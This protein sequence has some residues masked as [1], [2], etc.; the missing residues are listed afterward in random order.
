MSV[1]RVKKEALITQTIFFKAESENEFESISPSFGYNLIDIIA[2][3]IAGDPVTPTS[4]S[5]DI[6]VRTDIDGGFKRI[7]ERSNYPVSL[8]G[9]SGLADGVALEAKFVG[10]P[11]EFK[12]VP[13][14]VDVAVSYRVNIK[15]SSVQLGLATPVETS[16]RGTLGV[17]V[18]IQD[19]TTQSLD[20]LFS[21]DLDT[22][23]LDGATTVSS[24]F[25]DVAAGD[26][27]KFAVGNLI[28]IARNSTFMQAHVLG[29][30]SD[31]IEIESPINSV[32][33]DGNTVFIK[34]DN[35]KVDGSVTPQVF[36]ISPEP[37][38]VGDI[39]RI[40]I[41]LEGTLAMDSGTF[42]PLVAL[43]NG[44]VLRI[45]KADGDFIN[46][47]NFKTN[48]DIVS[49]SFAH[50]FLPNNG[51]NVRLFVAQLTW[52]G[53]QNHGVTQRL[54]GNFFEELQ[55]VIQ[56][57]LTNAAFVTFVLTAQGHETQN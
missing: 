50:S 49:K 42:G 55:I 21:Q 10:F 4:G 45:K 17:P 7:T 34:D 36:S 35:L 57:D 11:L 19:Q 56:D 43:T 41:S 14:N 33:P 8:T 20:L 46:L 52:A 51:Q 39:N 44:V 24:R 22:A 26:G 53:S 47:V 27:T 13:N 32:Y 29:I 48:G 1:K 40:I 6:F 30:V 37:L 3:D 28:E 9:G 18:F 38:Q 15:Q 2:L 23:T 31:T 5:F 12:I 25:F 54:D 16:G